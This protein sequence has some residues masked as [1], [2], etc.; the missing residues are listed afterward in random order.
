M[1][2]PLYP[3][4]KAVARAVLGSACDAARWKSVVAMLELEGFPK[5]D[6]ITGHRYW[7]AVKAF[8]DRRHGVNGAAPIPVTDGPETW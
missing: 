3:D 5:A 2:L 4:E 7:P 1:T 6:P 8:L